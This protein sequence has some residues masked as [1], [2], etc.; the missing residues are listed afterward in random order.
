MVSPAQQLVLAFTA[1]L[2]LFIVIPRL[3][4]GGGGAREERAPRR[5]PPLAP[6]ALKGPQPQQAF[7][8]VENMQQMKKLMEQELRGDKYKSNNKGYV[9]TLMPLYAIGVG[10]FAAYKF[11][12]IKSAEDTRIQKEKTAQGIKKSE[13]TENQLNELEQRLAQTEKMLNS[14][15]TQLDPLTNC[16]KSVAM[17]QKNEIM[18]QLQC[19]RDLMKKRGM[20]CPPINTADASCERNLDNLIESLTAMETLGDT[21]PQMH[22]SGKT[23]LY[24]PH[25]LHTQMEREEEDEESGE[26][27]E[28]EDE[29]RG[30]KEEDDEQ[31]KEADGC[32]SDSSMPSLEELEEVGMTPTAPEELGAGLRR[33][34]RPD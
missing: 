16:V 14:I 32:E 23:H 15:L 1:A 8:S 9:F 7:S 10:I 25:T 18:S 13:E 24:T 22:C 30:T 3:F 34:N 11:L 6:G 20:Q 26:K 31:D 27:D 21:K 2:C 4:G 17:E 5:G 33:R 19:I 29:E 12:K 28:E